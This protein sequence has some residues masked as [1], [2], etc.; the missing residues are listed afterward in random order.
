MDEGGCGECG[1]P[2]V[3]LDDVGVRAPAKGIAVSN[4]V[5]MKANASRNACVYV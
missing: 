5:S 4:T 1:V 3:G 2:F